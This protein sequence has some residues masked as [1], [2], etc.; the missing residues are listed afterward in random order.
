MSWNLSLRLL[1]YL[2]VIQVY[3]DGETTVYLQVVVN[4]DVLNVNWKPVF[5][6]QL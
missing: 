3:R 2:R 5:S 6:G 1:Y 4:S